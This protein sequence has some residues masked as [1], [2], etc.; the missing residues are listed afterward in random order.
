MAS[1]T[2]AYTEWQWGRTRTR[3]V[4]T[5][6]L[7][8]VSGL[9]ASYKEKAWKSSIL[10]PSMVLH[11]TENKHIQQC[12]LSTPHRTWPCDHFFSSLKQTTSPAP[13]PTTLF[14]SSKT[15]FTQPIALV[16]HPSPTPPVWQYVKHRP[17]H[18]RSEQP[19]G[20]IG[21]F[22]WLVQH[23]AKAV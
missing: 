23:W 6:R 10:D 16:S 9:D 14:A 1:T 19:S 22:V 7:I 8:L 18:P 3:H 15:P 11:Q 2:V 20:Y 21:R 4:G 13:V 12:P 17:S 5:P